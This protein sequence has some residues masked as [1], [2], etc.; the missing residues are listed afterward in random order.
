ME[1]TQFTNRWYK[2][3]ISNIKSDTYKVSDLREILRLS[4]S[5]PD[6]YTV[7]VISFLEHAYINISGDDVVISCN[8][9]L[10]NDTSVLMDIMYDTIVNYNDILEYKLESNL[11]NELAKSVNAD[12]IKNMK[13]YI[14]TVKSNVTKYNKYN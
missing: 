9:M 14:D 6:E 8:K 13:S 4:S 7:E 12:I 1:I 11:S 3:Y 10:G 5:I 2:V